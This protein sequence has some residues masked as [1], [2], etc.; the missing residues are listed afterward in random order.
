MLRRLSNQPRLIVP[1]RDTFYSFADAEFMIFTRWVS[2]FLEAEFANALHQPF[3]AVLH[4][5]WTNAAN[6]NVIGVTA[7]S[8]IRSGV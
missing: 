3:V 7:F 4:D 1:A 2:D 6:V 8:S 5:L